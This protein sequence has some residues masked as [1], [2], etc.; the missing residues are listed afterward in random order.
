MNDY[1]QGFRDAFNIIKAF[2]KLYIGN[3]DDKKV[4][5]LLSMTVVETLMIINGEKSNE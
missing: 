3:M 4:L 2:L 1:T 5:D